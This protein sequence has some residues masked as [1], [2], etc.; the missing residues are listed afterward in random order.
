MKCVGGEGQVYKEDTECE[1][2]MI[3]QFGLSAEIAPNAAHKQMNAAKRRE[4]AIVLQNGRC[5]LSSLAWSCKSKPRRRRKTLK[6]VRGGPY[7]THIA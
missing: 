2:I 4:T 3:I 1:T 6:N 5:I 7:L